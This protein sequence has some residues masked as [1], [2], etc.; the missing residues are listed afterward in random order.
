[1]NI[2]KSTK[3]NVG[4]IASLQFILTSEV[5]KF[6]TLMKYQ[7]INLNDIVLKSPPSGGTEGGWKAIYFTPE[8]CTAN[9]ESKNDD[10]GNYYLNTIKFK[11]PCEND[12][13]SSQLEAIIDTPMLVLVRNLNGTVKLFGTPENPMRIQYDQQTD[14]SVM[15]Q[16]GYDIIISSAGIY[17]ALFIKKS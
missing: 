9:S 13:T 16:T 1:M 3:K 8:T 7:P 14:E 15:K 2:E 4:G 12:E 10:A 6:P 5:D 11:H 17:P